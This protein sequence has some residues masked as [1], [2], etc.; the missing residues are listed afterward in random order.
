[1]LNRNDRLLAFFSVSFPFECMKGDAGKRLLIHA[2]KKMGKRKI[3]TL[4]HGDGHPGNMFFQ[5]GIDT[6]TWIDW[7]MYHA[8]P[9]GWECGQVLH[10]SSQHSFQSASS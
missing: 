3:Q 8:G 5:K 10:Q 6:F 7:Q 9:P 1:M 2:C 4:V